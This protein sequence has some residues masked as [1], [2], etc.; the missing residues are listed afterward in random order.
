[1]LRKG[2]SC[3]DN[4]IFADGMDTLFVGQNIINLDETESTNT[5][6]TNLLKQIP[7][8]EGTLVFTNKQTAGRGQVGNIWQAESGKNLT[9]S[10]VLHPNFLTADK[11]F[12]LSKITSLAVFGMLTEFLDSSLY[13][14]K[15]KWPNDILVNNQKI[16]GILIE[17]ILRANFLQSSV[18]GVGIN[19]NQ[20]NFASINKQV[21]SLAALLKK[22]FD[23]KELLHLF[24]KRFEAL[25]LTLKQGNFTKITQ[26]YLQ[27]L[28]RFNQWANYHASN[29]TFNAKI[30][31]IEENGLFVL[32]NRQNQTLIFNFKE[33]VFLD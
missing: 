20:T 28:Y 27:Q 33:I 21:T 9:F 2:T 24:C 17:N 10:L 1:M 11:Q 16:A 3:K 30:I 23:L 15:I 4:I 7:V 29:E 14:I 32:S 6:A 31:R 8:A 25:Y 19:I 22:E 18:I 5:Y 12:Y 26:A 13:D